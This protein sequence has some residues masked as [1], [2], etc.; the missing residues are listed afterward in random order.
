[1]PTIYAQ[2][3]SQ[4]RGHKGDITKEQMLAIFKEKKWDEKRRKWVDQWVDGYRIKGGDLV[5]IIGDTNYDIKIKNSIIEDGLN[6]S[7]VPKEA[8]FDPETIKTN[9]DWDESE[10]SR[11][12]RRK[13]SIKWAERKKSIVRKVSNEIDIVDSTINKNEKVYSVDATKTLFDANVYFDGVTFIGPVTFDH[14]IFSGEEVYFNDAIFESR[15]SFELVVFFSPFLFVDPKFGGEVVFKKVVFTGPVFFKGATFRDDVSFFDAKFNMIDS[16]DFSHF[17]R[18]IFEMG[19]DFRNVTFYGAAIFRG[20]VFKSGKS[21]NFSGTKIADANFNGTTFGGSTSFRKATFILSDFEGAIF[22]QDANFNEAAFAR[23]A[24]FDEVAFSG[25][26]LFNEAFFN[27]EAVFKNANFAKLASFKDSRFL[28]KSDFSLSKF[29]KNT[30]FRETFIKNLNFNFNESPT[31]MRA[32]LDFRSATILNARFEDITFENYADFSD[33]KFGNVFNG[34][35]IADVKDWNS[36]L[37]LLKLSAALEDNNP[38]IKIWNNLHKDDQ[39]RI[40][41]FSKTG[42]PTV[43]LKFEIIRA[44]NTSLQEIDFYDEKYFGGIERDDRIMALLNKGM[45]NLSKHEIRLLNRL[46]IQMV[47]PNEIKPLDQSPGKTAAAI[48]KFL[49]F[50][51]NVYFQRTEFSAKAAF[52]RINFN[53]DANF[54][55]ADF[56]SK[57]PDSDNIFS[58]SYLNFNNLI[59]ESDSLPEFKYW[60]TDPKYRIK[61][62][63]SEENGKFKNVN[64]KNEEPGNSKSKNIEPLEPLSQVLKGIEENF[65][66]NNQLSDANKAH[67]LM[68]KAELREMRENGFTWQRILKELERIFWGL[69][70][71]YGTN[72][73]LIVGWTIFFNLFFTVIYLTGELERKSSSHSEHDF[74]FKIRLFEFPEQYLSGHSQSIIQYASIRKFID[75]LRFS[76]IVLFKVGR[77]DTTISGQFIGVDFKYIVWLE[78][79]LGF[80]LLATL[81]FTLK[82]TLPLINTLI[83]GVF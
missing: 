80:Y 28:G 81:V 53:G 55:D 30:D 1:M 40:S 8:H 6:F 13:K 70:S 5:E 78:W 65:R 35:T 25:N 23:K 36:L 59:I 54:K 63:E 33:V 61:I 77:R 7:E 64:P 11:W 74:D 27:G 43:D 16:A 62:L 14:S 32:R 46:L 68:K 42:N 58:L 18:A 31:T 2:Q 57:Y 69:I 83:T 37:N 73:G 52:E 26:A 15:A 47:Y 71:G 76:S 66:L 19:A 56:R 49:T 39:Q 9:L 21:A 41:D 12:E 67:F 45:D 10:K 60:V 4:P 24:N 38:A 75:T 3:N 48:F 29:N 44:I 51:S 34:L 22:S 72:I 20:A 79:L 82:N 17:D 50:E